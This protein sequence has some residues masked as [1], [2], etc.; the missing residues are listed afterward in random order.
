MVGL[1]L[2]ATIEDANELPHLIVTELRLPFLLAGGAAA[3][4]GGSLGVSHLSI[5]MLGVVYGVCGLWGSTVDTKISKR[6]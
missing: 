6:T 1:V 3:T 2:P 5:F 4:D